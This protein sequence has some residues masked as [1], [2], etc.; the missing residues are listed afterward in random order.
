MSFPQ[1]NLLRRL[2]ERLNPSQGKVRKG[3]LFLFVLTLL[4]AAAVPAGASF[5]AWQQIRDRSGIEVAGTFR[6]HWG[7]WLFEV[8]DFRLNWNGRIRLSGNRLTVEYDPGS[9]FRQ[10]GLKVRVSGRD[11]PA[12]LD[13]SMAVMTGRSQLRLDFL[14]AA[15]ILDR[16]GLKEVTGLDARAGVFQFRFGETENIKGDVSPQEAAR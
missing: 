11:L 4:L 1:S 6:P 16:Q 7:R 12:E 13:E 15:L 3:F 10:D 8:R 5:W 14:E 2:R 9:L